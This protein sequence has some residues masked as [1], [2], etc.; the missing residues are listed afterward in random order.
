MTA[1]VEVRDKQEMLAELEQREA[2]IQRALDRERDNYMEIGTELAAIKAR[3]LYQPHYPDFDG[4]L[5]RRWR[6]KRD[7]ANKQIRAAEAADTIVSAVSQELIPAHEGAIRP[8][9]PL[10]LGHGQKHRDADPKAA[11][12]ILEAVG[13]RAPAEEIKAAVAR[14]RPPKKP[15]PVKA[16]KA[17]D[18]PIPVQKVIKWLKEL[19]TV[20]RTDWRPKLLKAALLGPEHARFVAKLLRER[21]AEIVALAAELER[22]NPPIGGGQ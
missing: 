22:R 16:R 9:V 11:V 13:A 14:V 2:K 18:V 1:A 7:Y 12:K 6:F 15:I 20:I 4:Y 5:L 8:L 10:I 21:A 19:R 17:G 3:K